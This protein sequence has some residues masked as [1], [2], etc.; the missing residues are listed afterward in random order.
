MKS[1]R[2]FPDDFLPLIVV[3]GDR[4]EIP[5]RS[6]GD[7]LAYSVSSTDFMYLNYLNLQNSTI[8]SDKQF[9]ID[10]ESVLKRRFGD[11]NILVIGSPAVNLFSRQ[12]N[13]NA[14]FRFSISDET[15]EELN[16]QQQFIN[17]FL[18]LE[19]DYFI[20]YQCLEGIFNINTII[21]RFVGLNPDIDSL[22]KKTENI[23]ENF[24]KTR[25]CSDLINHPRPIKYLMHKLDRPGIYDSIAGRNRGE[26]FRY[27]R[28]YGLITILPNHFS[29]NGEFSIIFVAGVHGPGTAHGLK[30]LSD[31]NAFK[32]HPYGGVFQVDL[33]QFQG[34]FFDKIQLSRSIWETRVYDENVYDPEILMNQK[35]IQAFLSS[36]AKKAD[37][38]QKIFN[39]QIKDLFLEICKD[40]GYLLKIEGPYTIPLPGV[41]FWNEILKYQQSCTFVIHDVTN[42]S[43]G[44]MVEIGFSI[45]KKRRH[46]LIWNDKKK[47]LKNI[48][49][50]PSL[51]I[52]ENIEKINLE[53]YLETRIQIETK[54]LKPI[55]NNKDPYGCLKCV[56]LK[57]NKNKKSAFIYSSE[58]IIKEF[59]KTQLRER[60]MINIEETESSKEL[61]ICRICQI[62]RISDYSIVE[63]NDND[64]DTFIILGLCKALGKKTFLLSKS[65]YNS[66]DFPWAIEIYSYNL[67]SVSKNTDSTLLTKISTFLS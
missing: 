51:I 67:V 31:K 12:I 35:R 58:P 10:P 47:V 41:D 53:N 44:V 61:K 29:S 36:P 25:I 42:Y 16:E 46:V 30:L 28:D 64:L 45:G 32:E 50:T 60:E 21:S 8:V 1:L 3:S 38:D 7:L 59:V 24:K 49:K 66:Q 48:G 57:K 52:N 26:T 33:E 4:R 62:L 2:N 63:I 37:Q 39:K 18:Q 15:K 5:P 13:H 22:K 17:D 56:N 27:N 14:V 6:K 20:Y 23:V 9:V 40:M 19:D 43:K 34:G 54:I 65:H 11:K 55:L